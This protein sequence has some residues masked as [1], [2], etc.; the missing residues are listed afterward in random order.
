MKH[1]LSAV[2]KATALGFVIVALIVILSS[3]PAAQTTGHGPSMTCHVT[4]GTAPSFGVVPLPCEKP[5]R[6]SGL[7]VQNEGGDAIPSDS[8]EST[9]TTTASLANPK[10]T[11]AP[12]QLNF[13]KEKVGATSAFKTVKLSNKDH[14]RERGCYTARR[15][16]NYWA[17]QSLV[18]PL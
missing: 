13:K 6:S 4:D 9:T 7:L 8:N 16:A 2:F 12:K 15:I 17:L 14:R 5:K 3:R 11:G 10:L 1:H 18:K